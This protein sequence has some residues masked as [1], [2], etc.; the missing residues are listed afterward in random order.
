MVPFDIAPEF[1]LPE[2]RTGGGLGRVGTSSMTVPEA[3]V[4]KADSCES[5]E[6]HVRRPGEL[7]VMET[8]PEAACMQCPA[9]GQLRPRVLPPN[10]CHHSR[11]YC[12]INYVGHVLAFITRKI[13]NPTC[14][15]LNI[16]DANKEHGAIVRHI[17]QADFKHQQAPRNLSDLHLMGWSQHRAP[18]PRFVPICSHHSNGPHHEQRAKCWSADALP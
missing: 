10:S 11:S 6:H 7:P 13:W 4:H 17:P 18:I 8:V 3:A 1:G 15:P 14:I 9:K 12:P 2:V 16:I 5:T